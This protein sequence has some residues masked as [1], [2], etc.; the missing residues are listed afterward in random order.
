MGGQK[1]KNEIEG[2]VWLHRQKGSHTAKCA[3]WWQIMVW[4][5]VGGRVKRSSTD[6]NWGYSLGPGQPQVPLSGVPVSP[7]AKT[8]F[9]SANCG[10]LPEVLSVFFEV[11]HPFLYKSSL[12]GSGGKYLGS[13][14]P[15]AVPAPASVPQASA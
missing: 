14:H 1:K 3:F 5:R 10:P 6:Q 11:A 2:Y 12:T 15:R 7:K 4:A 8:S 13:F 9:F